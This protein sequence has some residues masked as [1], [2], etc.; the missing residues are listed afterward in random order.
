MA[1]GEGEGRNYIFISGCG[2]SGTSLMAA[3]IGAHSKVF[4]INVETSVFIN[5]ESS[6]EI[7]NELNR[8][9]KGRPSQKSI[10]CEKTPRHIHY[11]KKIH[12]HFPC[13]SIIVMVRD[14]RDVCSSLKVRTGK[15][16]SSIN[17]WVSDYSA[18]IAAFAAGVPVIFLEYENLVT[19]PITTLKNLCSSISLGYEEEMLEFYKDGR[20]WFNA[21]GMSETTGKEGIEH[22]L[23][24]NW[25]IHQPL[26]DRRGRWKE[27][28]DDADADEIMNRCRLT[29]N[30]FKDLG[31]F[32]NLQI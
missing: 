32:L 30:R 11:L 3:M 26:M 19:E 1:M 17:R 20:D 7:I 21:K 9:I 29:V 22:R 27:L 31:V 15:L 16:E 10:T 12:T 14:P 4:S 13:A 6:N 23:L 24:R 18:A 5:H 2:H 8:F 28:I 25:Q